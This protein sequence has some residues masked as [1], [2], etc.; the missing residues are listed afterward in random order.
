MRSAPPF[1]PRRVK[2][3]SQTLASGLLRRRRAMSRCMAAE[4]RQDRLRPSTTSCPAVLAAVQ[5]QRS[6]PAGARRDGRRRTGSSAARPDWSTGHVHAPYSVPPDLPDGMSVPGCR[7]RRARCGRVSGGRPGD[8]RPRRG[9]EHQELAEQIED[10]R[11]RY[12]VLDDPTLSDADYD[13]RLRRLQALEEEWPELRTPDSPTQKVGGAVSTDF[14]AV[15]HLQ[16]ME[17]L[18]NAFTDEELAVLVRAARARRRAGAR[19][20]VRAQGRRARDQ[21]ALRGRPAGAGADPWRRAHRRGRHAQRQDD[22]LHPAPADGQPRSLPVPALVE[23]RGEVFLPTEAFER[24]NE[25]HDRRRQAGVRQPAQ[26]RGRVAAPEGP[27]GDRDPRPRHGLP[28]HRRA[29]GVRADRAV[30]GV[31]RAARLG[32]ADQRPGAGARLAEGGPRVHRL[33]RRAPPRRRARDRR[34]RG[35]G[36]RRRRCSGGSARRRGRRAGR[37]P[38]STRPRRSTPGCSRSRSTPAAPAGSRRSG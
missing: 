37:S 18:D 29:R 38:S 25:S 28:R 21:P 27:A 30:R 15:D 32:A 34:G 8:A 36:R 22:R 12:F 3:S 19:P 26:R 14:T 5:H 33:L 4:R 35:Q 7:W 6:G 20:A 13:V 24:L 16:R 1:Q 31:R 17:S 2:R 23:V 9:R 10:A 11:W